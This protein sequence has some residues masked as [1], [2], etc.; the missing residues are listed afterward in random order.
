MP[1]IAS[2]NVYQKPVKESTSKRKFSQDYYDVLETFNKIAAKYPL[3]NK[4]SERKMIEKYKNNRSKLNSLLFYHNIRIV[5]NLA[6]KYI[7]KAESPADLLMNGARGLMIATEKFD[8][9]KNIKFNTYA[10]PWVF[11]YILML[12]YSK[13]PITGVNQTSLNTL[14]FGAESGAEQIDYLCDNMSDMDDVS[15]A[16]S[17]T[18]KGFLKTI[19]YTH[20]DHPSS[21]PSCE[22]EDNAN[23]QLVQN[24]ISAIS[25]DPQFNDIDRDIIYNNMM[26]NNAS[27]NSIAQKY[28]VQ[29]KDVNKRKRKIISNFKAM[30][31]EKYNV[32]SLDDIL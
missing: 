30:L 26:A 1:R 22:Y 21:S 23:T 19:D 27:I 15:T 7:Q 5:L 10:T 17:G 2:E 8:I 4:A 20:F 25:A 3:L 24:V 9:D 16:L 28:H 31:A 29:S 13:S 6:K 11:K 18:G 32:N 14:F 12:F